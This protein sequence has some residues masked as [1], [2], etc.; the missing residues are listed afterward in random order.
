MQWA[1]TVVPQEVKTQVIM[2]EGSH[3]QV[4][5][6]GS[7]AKGRRWS[8]LYQVRWH[9][10]L[11]RVWFR[12]HGLQICLSTSDVSEFKWEPTEVL[13]GITCLP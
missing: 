13:L 3:K 9:E 5:S 1:K 4:L 2:E 6:V 8:T 12:L 10:R 7:K 11:D